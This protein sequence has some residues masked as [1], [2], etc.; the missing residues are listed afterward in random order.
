MTTATINFPSSTYG[1][2]RV[3]TGLSSLGG[4]RD[5][6]VHL[7]HFD[8]VAFAHAGNE[9]HSL[10]LDWVDPAKTSIDAAAFFR[11]RVNVKIGDVNPFHADRQAVSDLY[12]AFLKE[13]PVN[14]FSASSCAHVV[15]EDKPD[16]GRSLE[17]KRQAA[18]AKL[19]LE[20]REVLGL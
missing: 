1:L 13:R 10:T 19:T 9:L 2:W 6:G 7:G 4:L 3:T 16:S 14:V 8:E 15:L 11:K 17:M 20:D 12:Y 5:L 18:L